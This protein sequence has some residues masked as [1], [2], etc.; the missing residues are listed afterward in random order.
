MTD[1]KPHRP[2]F[3]SAILCGL[4]ALAVLLVGCGGMEDTATTPKTDGVTP[5]EAINA[6]PSTAPA[7]ID[8]AATPG[9]ITETPP[10]VVD[11]VATPTIEPPRVDPPKG[12]EAEPIVIEEPAPSSG[13]PKTD[14][15]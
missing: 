12:D 1:M 10:T 8:G 15:K 2:T 13:D 7:P 5:R 4:P 11:P 14:S 6:N 3:R 9:I